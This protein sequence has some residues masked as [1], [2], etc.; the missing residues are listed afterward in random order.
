MQVLFTEGGSLAWDMRA[1][2]DRLVR[3]HVTH[4]PSIL[5][6]VLWRPHLRYL[7]HTRFKHPALEVS[8]QVVHSVHSVPITSLESTAHNI[9]TD[10]W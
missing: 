8:L 9:N 1:T 6:L 5:A 4:A 3:G 7:V 2:I 10:C